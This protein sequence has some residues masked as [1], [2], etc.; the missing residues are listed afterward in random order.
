MQTVCS[1][2]SGLKCYLAHRNHHQYSI[3]QVPQRTGPWAV[4]IP[5]VKPLRFV[6]DKYTDLYILRAFCLVSHFCF[7][8][9]VI[10]LH[11]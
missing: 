11:G 9:L 10:L 3:R 2:I 4:R 6:S 5:G 1:D 8:E 7:G